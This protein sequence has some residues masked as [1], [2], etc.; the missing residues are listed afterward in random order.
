MAEISDSAAE[1]LAIRS[2]AER[3]GIEVIVV[4]TD[5]YGV[6]PVD[7]A[8]AA[9]G[10]LAGGHALLVKGSRVVGLERWVAV[11]QAM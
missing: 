9:V 8:G 5:L 4:G 7:D 6:E 3:L 11:L 2:E 10:A 1:H